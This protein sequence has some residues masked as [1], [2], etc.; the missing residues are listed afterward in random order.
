MRTDY[1][2]EFITLTEVGNFQ[3]AADSLYISQSTLSKHIQAIEKELGFSLLSHNKNKFSLTPEGN[4]FL[5]FARQM[6]DIR[7][8]YTELF[9]NRGKRRRLD[10][11]TCHF[12][13]FEDDAFSN[14]I[15]KLSLEFPDCLIHTPPVMSAD[16]LDD[17][18]NENRRGGVPCLIAKTLSSIRS[19]FSS[20]EI[21]IK[22]LL[23]WPVSVLTRK[24]H[25]LAGSEI[26]L[27]DIEN[28]SL[29]SLAYP[30]FANALT[31]KAFQSQGLIPL[32][33]NTLN[34]FRS[35]C[36]FVL[37]GKGIFVVTEPQ[38]FSLLGS[39]LALT[40]VSPEISTETFAAWNPL[41]SKEH[42]LR[43]LEILEE[44]F[45]KAHL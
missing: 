41:F 14:A 23:S 42:D 6:C 5:P 33:S 30:T 8:E 43:F 3:Y 17:L 7:N 28:E 22:T 38:D 34:S 44:E 4:D 35:V 9:K 13:S 20:D 10:I 2:Y 45:K 12:S 29:I 16:N 24:D 37:N 26:S 25:P 15:L 31:V 21:Q 40:P 18:L 19:R 32:F 27:K 1:L 36:D 39:E 11:G